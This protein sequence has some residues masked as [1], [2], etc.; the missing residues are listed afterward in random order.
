MTNSGMLKISIIHGA[1]NKHDHNMSWNVKVYWLIIKS[2]S[3]TNIIAQNQKIITRIHDE[4]VPSVA[5]TQALIKPK[6]IS[7]IQ[8]M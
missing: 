7:I 4:P 2:K 3:I 5:I 6:I 8:I 1:E